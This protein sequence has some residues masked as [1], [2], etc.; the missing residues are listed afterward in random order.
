L[1]FPSFGYEPVVREISA[2]EVF[3]RLTQA[4]TNYVALGEAGFTTL[5]RFI[6]TVPARAIDYR[7]GVEAETL[8]N[9]LW[10]ELA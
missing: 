7:D 4:S 6:K 10:S 1:L 3:M 5:T 2:S 9:Q 8:V